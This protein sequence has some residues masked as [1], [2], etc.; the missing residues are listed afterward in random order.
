MTKS[1]YLLFIVTFVL[2]GFGLVAIYS[3]SA[4]FA[5]QKFGDSLFF[6]KRQLLWVSLGL[7]AMLIAWGVKYELIKSLS[8][9]LLF[10]TIA[11][12]VLVLFPQFG[13]EAGGARRWLRI[14]AVGF[15]P[16]ELGKLALILYLSDYL[17][18]KQN[19]IKSF[20]RGFFPP[21]LVLGGM[22]GLILI[23]PD[24]GTVVLLGIVSLILLFV[25]GI[26]IIYLGGLV[27]SSL[28]A[29]YFLISGVGYRQRRILAFLNPWQHATGAGYQIV[30]SFL[31]LG[32]GGVKGV[33]LGESRQKLFYLP[34]SYTDFIF[35]IVGEELGFIGTVSLVVL[36]LV[37]LWAGIRVAY[38]SPDLFGYLLGIG[39]TVAI[40]L[41]AIMNIG[42]A[43]GSLPTKGISLPFISF[44]GSSLLFNMM[45]VGLLL[46]IARRRKTN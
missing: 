40:S 37:F 22:A 8:K 36:F 32:S 9:P 18:R 39:I 17:T 4:I 42:V 13:R 19:K 2:I 29:L 7:V 34:A 10:L 27:L 41:Q 35:S 6:L 5:Q 14:G 44:G 15:Q 25:A 46:N 23:Q 21:M 43:T 38:Q 16:S 30:Q 33:G 26:R 28:P 1:G 3:T 31:A 24:L 12:L 11:L 45:G 20:S